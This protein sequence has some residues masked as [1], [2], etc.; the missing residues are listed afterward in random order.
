MLAWLLFVSGASALVFQALWVRELGLVVGVDVQATALVVAGFFGGLALG[1]GNL[2]PLADRSARPLRL[3]ALFELGSGVLGLATTLVFSVSAAWFVALR[4]RVGFLAWLP[5]LLTIAAPAALM[6]GTLPALLRARKPGD[7]AL[8]RDAGALYGANTAGAIAG[9]LV[10][11]FWLVPTFGVRG[12]G[13]VAA[14]CDLALAALAWRAADPRTKSEPRE[15]SAARPTATPS[16]PIRRDLRWVLALYAT[17][18]GVAVGYEILWTQILVQLSSTRAFAFAIVLA[19]YLG[20]LALGSHAYGRFADRVKNGWG[21]FGLLVA[22]AGGAALLGVA[23]LGPWLLASQDAVGSAVLS[24]TGNRMLMMVARFALASGYLVFAPTVLLGAAYPAAIRLAARAATVGTDAGSVSAVNTAGGVA[25]SLLAGFVLLPRFGLVRSLALLVLVSTVV[26]LAAVVHERT[27]RLHRA[28]AVALLAAG[29]GGLLFTP[30]DKLLRLLAGA[31]GGTPVFYEEAASGSVAVL[32]QE[33]RRYAFRRLYIQGVSNT[34]DAMPSLR[35][36]RL[37]ALLPLFAAKSAPRSALV[38]GL[39]TGITCGTLATWPSLERRVCVELSPAVVQASRYFQGNFGVTRDPRFEIRVADGRHA[40]LTSAERHDVITLEPPPPA[41][42]GVVN[43]Y[44]RD[45]YE[46]ARTRLTEGGALAQWWPLA[47]QN[48]EDSRS[49]VRSFLDAFPH[50]ALFTTEL[51]EMLLLG[52]AQPLRVDFARWL[53]DFEAPLVARA[54]AEV[55]VSSPAALLATY[56]TDRAGL[57]EYASGAPPVTDDDPR[58]EY[59]T[60]VRPLELV[61]VLPPLLSREN[62][63]PLTD[64]LPAVTV[65][66]AAEQKLLHTFYAA[67][68]ASMTQDRPRFANAVAELGTALEKNPYFIS[69]LGES[70]RPPGD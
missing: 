30:S 2:G 20:G 13:V 5:L 65:S 38:I 53:S 39:G 55:G 61:R 57:E 19:T 45:F 17:A 48:D 70:T 21:A 27:P 44:S 69:F 18:G 58:I 54:L 50:V 59:A 25:G 28:A 10:A 14:G 33:G 9:V 43:L 46:L 11:P 64:E 32:E 42:A 12:T 1:S 36:M 41:A 24:A 3:Y 63:P 56:V 67:G 37:Q 6:G 23:L 51:H 26:G 40:L 4:E 22:G 8:G 16:L 31:H 62:S 34:G 29:A 15:R 66:I 49:L 35:Y 47:T 68:L 7:A 60:W 52:S